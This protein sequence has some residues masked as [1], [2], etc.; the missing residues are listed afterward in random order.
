M[1]WWDLGLQL[2]IGVLLLIRKRRTDELA[3]LLL[4]FFIFTTYIP[5]PVFGF[6]WTLAIL[7]FA[8]AKD[9]FPKISAG[10]L[11]S[12]IAILLY[13]LPWRDWVLG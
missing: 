10:Y 4:L 2:S 7:G 12:F 9:R 3:H 5:A 13:Q 1:T 8:L 11:I 6:G